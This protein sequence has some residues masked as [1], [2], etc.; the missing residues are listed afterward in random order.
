[1]ISVA[2]LGSVGAE[3]WSQGE[4]VAVQPAVGH[5]QLTAIT[6]AQGVSGGTHKC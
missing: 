1:M 5:R 3:G 6:A 4:R 2:L